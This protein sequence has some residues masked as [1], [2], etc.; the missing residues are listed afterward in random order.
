MGR[1]ASF[2]VN[3]KSSSQRYAELSQMSQIL[4]KKKKKKRER[5]PQIERRPDKINDVANSD[6]V[7]EKMST[8]Q[9]LQQTSST[10]PRMPFSN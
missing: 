6:C 9:T 1:R 8:G 5:E 7:Q 2:V 3:L 4:H 10:H